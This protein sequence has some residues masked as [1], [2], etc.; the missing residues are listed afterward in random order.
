MM[1]SLLPVGLLIAPV[2]SALSCAP[3]PARGPRPSAAA[4]R[5]SAGSSVLAA[6]GAARDGDVSA[7]VCPSRPAD[8]ARASH[9]VQRLNFRNPHRTVGIE[10]S[11]QLAG[12][13]GSRNWLTHGCRSALGRH[14]SCRLEVFAALLRRLITALPSLRIAVTFGKGPV[15]TGPRTPMPPL[16]RCAARIARVS[17]REATAR[18]FL[19]PLAV[20]RQCDCDR[21]STLGNSRRRGAARSCPSAPR[22]RGWRASRRCRRRTGRVPW[23]FIASGRPGRVPPRANPLARRAPDLHGDLARLPQSSQGLTPVI[24]RREEESSGL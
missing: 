12:R 15:P 14:R 4:A 20:R 10:L 21:M 7:P 19:R 23:R 5:A 18:E 6:T 11:Q 24:V 17:F 1:L 9:V 13:S 8:I 22:R 16:K 2:R 3:Q